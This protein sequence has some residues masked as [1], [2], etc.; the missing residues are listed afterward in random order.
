MT[1]ANGVRGGEVANELARSAWGCVRVAADEA[2][3]GA[4][5]GEV[6]AVGGD[7]AGGG[8]ERVEGGG[9]DGGGSTNVAAR[10]GSGECW[11]E[12]AHREGHRLW[13]GVESGETVADR[14][15]DSDERTESVERRHSSDDEVLEDGG[16][17]EAAI[18]APENL[19]A[20]DGE[21]L[22]PAL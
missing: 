5:C 16:E 1:E 17:V 18:E 2:R 6:A 21:R 11:C 9:G 13:A 8:E 20:I 15:E 7:A 4:V 19:S 3:G 14:V 22:K 12:L 10:G